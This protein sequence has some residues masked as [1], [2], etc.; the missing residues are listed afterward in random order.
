MS[1]IGKQPIQIPSGVEVTLNGGAI[2][3]KGPKGEL[4]LKIRPEVEVAVDDDGQSIVVTRERNSRP[5]RAFHGMTRAL[6]QN[7]VTGVSEG[8]VKKLEIH[9]VGY[10]AK[11]EGDQLRLNIGFCHPVF[12]EMPPGL[13]VECPTNTTIVVSGT[14]RQAVGQLAA[15]VRAVRP[16]EPYNAKGIRYEGEQIQRKAGKSFVSSD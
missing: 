6:I 14:D 12:F 16:P 7:M 15:K 1:R 13:T 9:G 10:N 11:M 3:V 5:A 4:D 8:F 2:A